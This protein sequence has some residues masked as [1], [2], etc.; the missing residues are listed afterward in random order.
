MHDHE[1]DHEDED[2]C[3]PPGDVPEGAA[4]LP[5]IPKELGIHPLLLA[6]LHAVVFL[7]GSSEDVMNDSAA[8]EALNYMATYLQ[9]LEGADLK[10]IR[11]DII[12]LADFAKQEKWPQE[13]TLFLS[14]FLD[15]FGVKLGNAN[16][17]N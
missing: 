11:E 16:E 1:Q 14:T 8:N 15:D 4:V 13:E 7:D 3:G 6:T 10:R 2:P 9:R 5:L 17:R 12:C